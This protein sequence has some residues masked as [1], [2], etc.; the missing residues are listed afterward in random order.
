MP[1]TVGNPLQLT[2]AMRAR[3]LAAVRTLLS[4]PGLKGADDPV[5]L[6]AIV[7][8]AKAKVATDYSTRITATELGR[9][10]GLKKSRVAHH[11][12]PELRERGVLGSNETTNAAGWM[13]GLECW[14]VPMY[15][16][17]HGGDRRHALA[18]SK[19]E[20]IVLLKLIEALFAPGWTHE[21]GRVT[22]A[23]MLADRTGRGAAT[24]RLGLLL[25]VLSSNSKGWLQL[26]SGSV[27]T[28]RGRPAATVARLLGCSPA[29]GAK[30]LSR[31]QEQQDVL[32]VDRRE[33]ASGLHA[34]SRVRLLPVAKAHGIAVREARKAA[35]AVFSDLAGTASGDLEATVEAVTPVV[36]GVQGIGEGLEADSADRADA[37]HLHAPHAPVVTP[38][39][40]LSL[41][42]GSSGEGRG[43]NH[44]LPDR[45][46]VREDQAVDG[47][48]A[49]AGSAS[50][51]AE[52]GPLRGEQPEK[53]SITNRT[54]PDCGDLAATDDAASTDAAGPGT[55][56]HATL[57]PL[58]VRGVLGPV[59]WLW[60]KIERTGARTTVVRRTRAALDE[61]AEIVGPDQAAPAL[62]ARLTR[63]LHDQGGEALVTDPAAWI[64]GRGLPQQHT[65][66]GDAR[67]DGGHRLDTNTDCEACADQHADRQALR[68]Q[69]A[70]AIDARHPHLTGTARRTAIEDHL[71]T[72]V[73][74]AALLRQAR[75]DRQTAERSARRT[76][77]PLP[78]LRAR[79]G[80]DEPSGKS[81]CREC[82]ARIVLAGPAAQDLLCG[83]CH[84]ESTTPAAGSSAATPASTAPP[85]CTQTDRRGRPCSHPPVPDHDVCVRHLAH[86]LTGRPS[87]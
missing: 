47:E 84:R 15:R 63:R 65:G 68:R 53:A 23:G 69:A 52:G 44:G 48:G 22:P 37:A 26:C 32:S 33:T 51:V 57:P 5:R 42:G 1:L 12:V 31:L 6:A 62:T 81:T 41:S 73:Q 66:C 39:G 9:W 29:A 40:S 38:G 10:V 16:A 18:L 36:T 28:E 58:D 21:G 55:R 59:R 64:I 27:D 77:V 11:V 54:E 70:A 43:G 4:D 79:P 46:C 20:L 82:G 34:R 49:A 35:D 19:V 76:G 78:A 13:T 7:L 74:H 83:A 3:L 50:S 8:A 56:G 14:V 67:C 17:Q 45:A 71:H 61:L 86:A 30:V 72:E 80:R 75:H 85:A 25:M 87:S 60:A 2:K 24:D